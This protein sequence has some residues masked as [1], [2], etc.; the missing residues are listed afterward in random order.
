MTDLVFHWTEFEFV[1]TIY[2]LRNVRTM[3]DT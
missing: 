2:S 1:V 3:K